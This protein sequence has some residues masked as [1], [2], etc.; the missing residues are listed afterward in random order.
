MSTTADKI[1]LGVTVSLSLIMGI[2]ST[3]AL[4]YVNK[5]STF[6]WVK[7]MLVFCIIQD[8]SIAS[9]NI[10]FYIETLGSKRIS[11]VVGL[12]TFM[13]FFMNSIIYWIICF[14]YW[15]ISIIVPMRIHKNVEKGELR[16]S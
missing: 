5:N 2:I 14:K 8:I 15:T 6:K 3:S 16:I 1:A 13:F 12:S 10:S 4:V 11:W 9:L 7:M